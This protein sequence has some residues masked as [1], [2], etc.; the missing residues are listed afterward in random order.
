MIIKFSMIVADSSRSR[1]YLKILAD[2]QL[3]PSWILFMQNNNKISNIGGLDEQFLN[4]ESFDPL[5]PEVDFNLNESMIDIFSRLKIPYSICNTTDINNTYLV[6]KLKDSEFKIVI[7]SGYG[8]GILRDEILNL[9]KKFLHIHG[10]YLPKYKGSTTNYYSLLE[11]DYIAAS[12]IFLNS[13]IDCGPIIYREKFKPPKNK[14]N[15][16]HIY[17]SVVRA[18]VLINAIKI[19]SEKGISFFKEIK[20]E[21]KPYYIIHPLLK[22]IA[23]IKKSS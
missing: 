12:A 16:D 19:I 23:I 1:V 21:E 18:R 14:I 3:L 10:G 5:W 8:G 9:D 20:Q 2:N 11:E 6:E 17:D 13:K 15:I 22:H 4:Q 7:Y